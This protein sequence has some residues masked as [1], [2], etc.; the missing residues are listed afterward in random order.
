MMAI[1]DQE[2]VGLHT[3]SQDGAKLGGIEAGDSIVLR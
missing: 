3:F 2:L 1:S